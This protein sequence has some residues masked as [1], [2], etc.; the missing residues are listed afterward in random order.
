MRIESR[1]RIRLER[2]RSLHSYTK[3]VFIFV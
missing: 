2:L 3:V 1:V